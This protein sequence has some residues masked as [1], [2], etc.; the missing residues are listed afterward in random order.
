MNYCC[1]RNSVPYG[2]NTP[3]YLGKRKCFT[4]GCI[5]ERTHL[6]KILYRLHTGDYTDLAT[7]LGENGFRIHALIDYPELAQHDYNY[8]WSYSYGA[9]YSD[10]KTRKDGERLAIYLGFARMTYTYEGIKYETTQNISIG[11]NAPIVCRPIQPTEL[12]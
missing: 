12:F 2:G 11:N 8:G 6:D 4:C 1:T 10:D 9:L 5:W 7:F 3:L